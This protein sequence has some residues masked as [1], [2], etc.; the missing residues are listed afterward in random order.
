MVGGAGWV[1]SMSVTDR[2]RRSLLRGAAALAAAASAALVLFAP[3]GVLPHWA[4]QVER[5]ADA[6]ARQLV[7]GLLHNAYRAF[8]LRDEGAIYDRLAQSVDGDLLS[9]VYLDTR[10]S[11][12]VK[13]QGGLRVF[14]EALEIDELEFL[15]RSS[16]T[17]LA[18]RCGWRVS[19]SVGHWGHI[20]RRANQHLAE[21]SVG[22][23]DGTWKITS[24][25]MLDEQLLFTQST[26]AP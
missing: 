4:K 3:A 16:A 18:Y 7:A 21:V 24:L 20:H 8:D 19:G 6:E 14:V 10:R 23:R 5:P 9:Q 25:R 12:E 17:G 13:N 1:A 2:R 11:M 15:G 26:Q 22:P